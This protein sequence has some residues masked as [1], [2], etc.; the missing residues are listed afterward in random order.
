MALRSLQ[1]H[2]NHYN[3]HSECGKCPKNYDLEVTHF[4]HFHYSYLL[5][6]KL[7]KF[8]TVI[9]DINYSIL[10]L[11]HFVFPVWIGVLKCHKTWYLWRECESFQN[12]HLQ[13]ISG[14]DGWKIIPFLTTQKS[15]TMS[16]WHSQD[17]NFHRS[18]TS[19]RFIFARIILAYNFFHRR[20]FYYFKSGVF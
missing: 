2:L 14:F 16:N 12:L 5:V 18:F 13:K 1:D 9:S 3:Y 7:I 17:F 20:K 15:R 6:H 11:C 10:L 4:I 19:R 8:P